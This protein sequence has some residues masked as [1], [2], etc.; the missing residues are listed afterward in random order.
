MVGQAALNRSIGVRLPVSQPGG[1]AAGADWP[2]LAARFASLL[3]PL[4][5]SAAVRTSSLTPSHRFQPCRFCDL[6]GRRRQGLTART[7]GILLPR[8]RLLP[9]RARV[10]PPF[11]QND[12]YCRGSASALNAPLR[13]RLAAGCVALIQL[14]YHF[15]SDKEPWHVYSSEIWTKALLKN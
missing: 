12:H 13:E 10:R 6:R 8:A 7:D 1:T 9:L 4:H 14:C 2:S 15:A 11:L 5:A 3:R